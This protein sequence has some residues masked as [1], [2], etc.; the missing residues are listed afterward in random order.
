MKFKTTKGREISIDI[1]PS[2]NPVRGAESKSQFQN[3]VGSGVAARWP[4][5]IL[6]EEFFVP[7]E[8]IYI[9]Y[10]LPRPRI[11]VEADGRQHET[12]VPYF[13]GTKSGFKEAQERDDRKAKWC[14]IN[15]IKLIRVPHNAKA[16]DLKNLLGSA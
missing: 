2:N 11:A 6:L 3:M 10:F 13:H 16:E 9:D 15:N 4:R 5:D 14:S 8:G 7:G 12:F 1:R